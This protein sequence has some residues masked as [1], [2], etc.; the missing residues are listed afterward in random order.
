MTRKIVK[1]LFPAENSV[2]L[3]RTR[4]I[5]PTAQKDRQIGGKQ[6]E[7]PNDCFKRNGTNVEQYI[8]FS[9]VSELF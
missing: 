9:S 7:K 4:I 6:R 8:Q 1:K 3:R 2:R 5:T